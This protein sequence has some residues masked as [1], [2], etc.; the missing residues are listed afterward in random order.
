[1]RPS[2]AVRSLLSPVFARYVAVAAANYCL[3]VSGT[4]CLVNF[5]GVYYFWAYAMSLSVVVIINFALSMRWTFGVRGRVAERA[6]SYAFW[7]TFFAALNA[8]LVR[9]FTEALGIHYLLS[10]SGVTAS[11]FIL[12]YLTYRSRVFQELA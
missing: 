4:Y 3:L 6:R 8:A 10:I 12:K 9:L 7:L 2:E 5:A 11:L 1:M